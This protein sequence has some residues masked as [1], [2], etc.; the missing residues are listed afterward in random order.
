MIVLR[1]VAKNYR[2]VPALT[3]VSAHIGPGE[4]VCIVGASGSGKSTLL[5]LLLRAT[6]VT[7]G[8]IEVDGVDLRTLP[9][10][11]LQLYRQ[12]LGVAF[13]DD[14]LLD[15]LSVVENIALPLEL[16]GWP[17]DAIQQ[18]IG[19]ILS[20]TELLSIARS[21]PST[22][23]VGQR[24]LVSIARAC[25]GL[26]V[27]L[28]LDE[29]FSS[30]DEHEMHSAMALIREAQGRGATVIVFTQEKEWAAEL[31]ARV[32]T[33]ANGT[34]TIGTADRIPDRLTSAE[35]HRILQDEPHPAEQRPMPVAQT[36]E[37]QEEAVP[38]MPKKAAKPLPA[39][40]R[41]IRITAINS[42]LDQ[43]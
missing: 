39:G 5:H 29:P 13:Q 9:L 34:M 37:V 23:S 7:H 16:K 14:R 43:Q 26:P 42:D 32:L 10:P 41:K 35:E 6:D 30:L 19:D 8:S 38:E 28:L 36:T 20:K 27:I 24:R 4:C 1:S 21:Q 40:H 25:A 22:L 3:D 31:N 33:L 11:I 15:Q 12:R 2:S 17:D 18:Q